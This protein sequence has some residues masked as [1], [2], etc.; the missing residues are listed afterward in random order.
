MEDLND[1]VTGGTLTADEWNQVPSEIQNAI[2]GLGQTLTSSDLNQL[3]KAIAG[4]VANGTFYTDSGA[5]DAYVLTAIGSKQSPTAYTDG[6]EAE[7]VVGNTNTTSSTVNVATLGVISITDSS[8][9]GELTAGELVRLR[10]NDGS[11]EFDIANNTGTLITASDV[12]NVAAG[13]IVATDVQAAIDE[14]DTEKVGTASDQ[15]SQAW[16][17]FN[18][19]GTVAIND[20]LNVTSITDDGTGQYTINF[21]TTLADANYCATACAGTTANTNRDCAMPVAN[22]LTTSLLVETSTAGG[23]RAD[24]DYVGV[25]VMGGN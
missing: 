16:V 18:G 11:G 13:D 23:T 14:L 9:A 17:S 19:S 5:A 4:Y 25:N 22:I 24:S 20:D 12:T 3:G 21:T 10:Y 6:F 2:E 1:K 7:F 15:A 8:T